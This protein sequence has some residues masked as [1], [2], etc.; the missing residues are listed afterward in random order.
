[1]GGINDVQMAALQ[2]ITLL[3]DVSLDMLMAGAFET[4]NILDDNDIPSRP[5]DLSCD[6]AKTVVWYASELYRKM[7]EREK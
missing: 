1:M 2:A 4:S 7:K 5:E 6:Q 3:T